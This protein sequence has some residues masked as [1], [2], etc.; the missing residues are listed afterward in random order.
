[1]RIVQAG[2][3]AGVTLRVIG[4]LAVALHAPSARH[5]S[6]QRAY[7]DIDFVAQGARALEVDEILAAEGYAPDRRFNDM[8]GRRRLLYWDAGHERQVDVFVH[9]FAMC[10]AIPLGDR[11]ERDSP[12]VPLAELFLSKAQIVMLNEKDLLDLLALLTDHPVGSGDDETLNAD[13]VG[14]LCGRDWGLWR[15]VVGTLE[16]VEAALPG[17]DVTDAERAVV[18]GRSRGLRAVIDDAKKSVKWKARARL[19][20]RVQWYELPEDPRRS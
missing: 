19:G 6:L 13:V 10:H 7:A 15:T 20:D 18:L 17:W 4:G 9:E 5:R 12:T 14:G 16:K 3:A 11:L 2:A 8:N 1:V